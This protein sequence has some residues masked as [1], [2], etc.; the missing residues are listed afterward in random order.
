MVSTLLGSY[1]KVVQIGEDKMSQ[2]MEN[3]VHG[4][5][6]GGAI[7]FKTEIHDLVHECTQMG[8]EC[9][10]VLICMV[11]LYLVIPMEPVHEG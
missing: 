1:Y 2:I 4:P 3:V 11:N 6:E 5:L 8:C 7:I 9:S 10:F